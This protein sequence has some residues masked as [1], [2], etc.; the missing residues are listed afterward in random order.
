MALQLKEKGNTLFS[1][2]QYG[3]ALDVYAEALRQLRGVSRP[4]ERPRYPHMMVASR[5]DEHVLCHS[6]GPVTML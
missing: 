4:H 2:K 3:E 5:I 6:D 1:K